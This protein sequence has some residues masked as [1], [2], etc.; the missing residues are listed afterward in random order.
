MYSMCDF[1]CQLIPCS[2]STSFRTVFSLPIMVM[3][4]AKRVNNETG[5]MG[6]EYFCMMSSVFLC[7]L[8]PIFVRII[9]ILCV[10]ICGVIAIAILLI[11]T[12]IIENG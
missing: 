8:Q 5:C 9:Y 1:L 10:E 6:A 3:T 7:I 11:G 4:N 2:S 12:E